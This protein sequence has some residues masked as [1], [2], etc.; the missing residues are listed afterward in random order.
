MTRPTPAG[1]VITLDF[2]NGALHPGRERVELSSSRPRNCAP[3]S[4]RRP[5][6]LRGAEVRE[7]KRGPASFGQP[8]RQRSGRRRLRPGR[9]YNPRHFLERR[10]SRSAERARSVHRIEHTICAPSAPP[11]RRHHLSGSGSSMRSHPSSP[12]GADAPERLMC[13]EHRS[14]LG[15]LGHDR[16]PAVAD[17]G[18]RLTTASTSPKPDRSATGPNAEVDADRLWNRPET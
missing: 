10:R 8:D 2:F 18:P 14:S 15:H 16:H 17:P 11:C 12:K 1:D 6:R 9:P 4:R 13:S 3:H 5:R 7:K